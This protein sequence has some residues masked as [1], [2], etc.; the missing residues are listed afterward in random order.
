MHVECRKE[1]QGKRIDA[2]GLVQTDLPS[3]FLMADV[4]LKAGSVSV[5]ELHGTCPQHIN[6]IGIFG[7]TAAVQA[8]MAAIEAQGKSYKL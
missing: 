5:A 8:A 2:V 1:L 7:D 4:G 3:L 6:T